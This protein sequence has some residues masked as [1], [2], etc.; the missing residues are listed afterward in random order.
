MADSAKISPHITSTC[1]QSAILSLL[2]IYII[3][4]CQIYVAID[5][6]SLILSVSRLTSRSYPWNSVCATD[7]DSYTENLQSNGCWCFSY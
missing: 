1:V 6:L 2:I 4:C 7:D 5:N 3:P